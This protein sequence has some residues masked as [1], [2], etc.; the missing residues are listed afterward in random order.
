MLS[1]RASLIAL[2]IL[3]IAPVVR[4]DEPSLSDKAA[5]RDM[6]TDGV[7]L[8]EKGDLAG[9]LVKFK[10][11]YALW[12]S[13]TT[14]LELGRTHMQLGELI[15]A[16]E[17]FLETVKS[18]KKPGETSASQNARDEAQ[19]LADSLATRIPSLVFKISGAKSAKVTLDGRELPGETL[20]SPRK[21]NPGKHTIVARAAGAPD[22]NVEINVEEKETRE[23]PLAFATSSTTEPAAP[24]AP[25]ATPAPTP[26]VDTKPSSTSPLVYVGFGVAGVGLIVGG[27]TGAL[28]MSKAS[29]LNDACTDGRCPPANHADVDAYHRLGTISTI[30]FVAAGVGA[31]VG[32]YGVLSSPKKETHAH[33]TPFVGVGSIGVV[34]A[35]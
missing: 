14:G 31:A 11:A 25:T 33:I 4:A 30:S 21:V 7:A 22:L 27:V 23:V 32:I 12:P 15:E 19:K 6:F 13:A 18:P 24:A 10:G 5:A 1:L 8:R 16:R 9:A 28:A 20:S 29:S 2:S 34:G 26:V 3:S 35:F 17:R